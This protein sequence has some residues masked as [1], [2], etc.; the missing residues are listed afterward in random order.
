MIN[1]IL[2]SKVKMS[3]T[4]KE[5]SRIPVTQ[6]VAGPCVVTQIKSDDK[7]GYW[8]VQLGF[9]EKKLKN[10]TKPMQGHFKEVIKGKTAPRYTREV[11]L[12][13]KPEF[14]V[15]DQVKV[16]DIFVA[17]DIVSV[18]GISKGKGFAGVVKRWR[19]AG[20][21]KTHG[22]SDRQ[23]APGTIGQG[24]TPGRVYKGKHMGGRMGHETVT[25]KNLKVVEVDAEKNEVGVSGPIPGRPGSLVIIKRLNERKEQN[26]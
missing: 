17:G 16:S 3:Q 14:K 26:A 8:A 25:V 23:R 21:P 20:G 18:T 15:G 9:G 10:T 19:F 7:D 11:R 12:N 24:T 2:G 13:E 22:Q 6:I 4:F 1:T 5:G